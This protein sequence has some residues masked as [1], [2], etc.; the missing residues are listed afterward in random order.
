[1]PPRATRATDERIDM[2]RFSRAVSDGAS[3]RALAARFQIHYTTAARLR[4][5]ILT[6]SK[7]S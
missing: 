4:E 7:E 1:M 5:R 3:C 2:A 6:E